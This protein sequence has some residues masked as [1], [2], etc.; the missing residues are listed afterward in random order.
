MGRRQGWDAADEKAGGD[1][2]A[3]HYYPLYLDALS[4]GGL[5]RFLTLVEV[6]LLLLRYYELIRNQKCNAMYLT[7]LVYM[8]N[9]F[10]FI[11]N[12]NIYLNS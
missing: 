9:T 6:A 12:I 1:G 10:Y 11:S 7:R 5:F 3:P 8:N 2:N 4:D